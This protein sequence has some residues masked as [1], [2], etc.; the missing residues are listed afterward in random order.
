MK[1]ASIIFLVL[2][3][4]IIAAGLGLCFFAQN[5]AEKEGIELF[6]ISADSEGDVVEKLDFAEYDVG[7]IFL[8]LTECDI[9]ITKGDKSRA[10]LLNFA[11]GTYAQSFTNQT[12]S[13][14]NTI[15]FSSILSFAENKPKFNGIRQYLQY[16]NSSLANRDKEK[17]EKKKQIKIY[18]NP[19]D[20]I[21]IY[22]I[23]VSKGS[24]TLS[25]ITSRGGEYKITVGK[26]DVSVK[27][28]TTSSSVTVNVSEGNV[29]ASVKAVDSLNVDIINGDL[30]IEM[31]SPDIQ[32]YDLSIV[33]SGKITLLDKDIT[34]EYKADHPIASTKLKATVK[35]GDIIIKELKTSK[36]V[37]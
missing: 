12:F 32:T 24:V 23:K 2:S 30:N 27:N 7:R 1:P 20:Q 26:G 29:S 22:D 37:D 25:D 9:V 11:A 3:V 13:V 36:A 33:E 16:Y 31:Q 28:V 5:K 6:E 4:L 10:E 14:D 18:I 35:Q 19:E 21:K 17:E 8:N 34:G 15:S